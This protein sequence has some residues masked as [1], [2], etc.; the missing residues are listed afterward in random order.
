MPPASSIPTRCSP[1]RTAPWGLEAAQGAGLVTL[2]VAHSY[3]RGAL[4]AAHLVVQ[5]LIG[6]PPRSAVRQPG[7]GQSRLSSPRHRGPRGVD[8]ILR[9]CGPAIPT[10]ENVPPARS[11]SSPGGCSRVRA[12]SCCAGSVALSSHARRSR[13]SSRPPTSATGRER[14]VT[15]DLREVSALSVRDS[16]ELRAALLPEVQVVGIDEAQF[17]DDGLSIVATRLANGGVRVICAG[18][19]QDFRAGR[20]ARCPRC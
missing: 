7:R 10:Y 8:T 5:E 6:P 12:K 16:R 17:F 18:L 9:P 13:S 11:R 19:D 4:V 1:S 15:R 3:E 2:A 20:S 14:V